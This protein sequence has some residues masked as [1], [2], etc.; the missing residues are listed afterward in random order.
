VF[1][2]VVDEQVCKTM[3]NNQSNEFQTL[4]KY[5]YFK[6]NEYDEPIEFDFT[7]DSECRLKPT[8]LFEKAIDILKNKCNLFIE[9]LETE[10]E[11][12]IKLSESGVMYSLNIKNESHTLVNVLNNYIFNTEIRGN[13]G[14][15]EYIGYFQPHPLESNMHMK[16]KFSKTSDIQGVRKFISES[17]KDLID[18]LDDIKKNWRQCVAEYSS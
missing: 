4:E 18:T 11:E 13:K 17:V 3:P 7:I 1:S 9:N 8:Y 14:R 15:L 16:F 2:N 12:E 6:K 10:N 5:R